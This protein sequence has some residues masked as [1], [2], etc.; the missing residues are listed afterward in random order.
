M[1]INEKLKE[2]IFE[3]IK[4]Q[5]RENNPQETK[6]SYNRLL[7]LGFDK[8]QAKQMIAQCLVLEI[9]KVMKFRRHIT[10]K[11]SLEI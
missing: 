2:Q 7:K 5:M 11:G 1:E 10:M 9:F 6:E 3:I 4:N 8:F